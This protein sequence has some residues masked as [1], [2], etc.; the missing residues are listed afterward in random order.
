MTAGYIAARLKLSWSSMTAAESNATL[1]QNSTTASGSSSSGGSSGSSTSVTS[2]DTGIKIKADSYVFDD[3]VTFT[4][5]ALTSGDDY[6]TAAGL[7]EGDFTL[8]SISAEDENGDEVSPDGVAEVYIPVIEAYGE[9]V[10]IYRVVSEEGSEAYLT[11]LE[12]EISEDGQYYVL[13]VKEFGLF[14]VV[15]TEE[16][17]EITEEIEDVEEE[18]ETDGQLFDDIDGHWAEEYIIRAAEMGLFSGIDENSF[19]PDIATTRAMFVTVLGRLKGIDTDKYYE[20]GFNDVNSDDYFYSY[21]GYAAANDIVK[22]MD[23]DT[24][25]PYSN[26]TREQMALILCKFAE[27][28]GIELKTIYSTNFT[29]SNEIS[30]W[31]EE[32]VNALAAAG[33]INGRTDGSFDPKDEATRAEIAVMLLRFTDEYM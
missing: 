32:S 16:T 5:A 20:V 22:G 33:I 14:A 18:T 27:S 24:F 17:E 1:T 23:E 9:N 7:V 8:Y 6:D 2:D 10:V 28:E 19:G 29:D 25:A 3:D 12:Y 21:I 13:T 11:E 15:P 26:I 4:T 30:S 31:A